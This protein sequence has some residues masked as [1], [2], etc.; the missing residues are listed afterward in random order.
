MWGALHG[1]YLM[2]ERVLRGRMTRPLGRVHFAHTDLSG[3]AL[4]EEAHDHGVRAAE[5]VLTALGFA[6]PTIR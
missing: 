3:L 4:F 1:G 6:A 5:E 2:F